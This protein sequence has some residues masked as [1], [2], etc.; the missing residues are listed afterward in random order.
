MVAKVLACVLGL[1]VV[2]CAPHATKEQEKIVGQGVFEEADTN[3]DSSITPREWDHYSFHLFLDIDKD[4]DGWLSPDELERSFNTFD[5]NGDGRVDTLEAPFLA[6]AADTDGD[7]FVSRAEFEA[8]DWA[9]YK[10]DANNDAKISAAEFR[11]ARRELF[12]E[13][14]F[15]RN[16]R[17]EPVEFDDSARIILFRF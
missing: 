2:A 12:N 16:G 9:R 4:T 11:R 14:D 10:V 3:K 13:T 1:T 8:F 5:Q 15:D 17:L 7:R 6:G